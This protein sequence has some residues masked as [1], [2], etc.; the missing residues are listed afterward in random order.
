MDQTPV[1]QSVNQS[2]NQSFGVPPRHSTPIR[3]QTQNQSQMRNLQTPPQQSNIRVPLVTLTPASANA[4]NSQ[5]ER[6]QANP[7]YEMSADPNLNSMNELQNTGTTSNRTP[8]VMQSHLDQALNVPVY[9]NQ[10]MAAHRRQ[11]TFNTNLPGQVIINR[12]L[13]TQ[14]THPD[15]TMPVYSNNPNLT[16]PVDV[17]LGVTLPG[18]QAT[19]NRTRTTQGVLNRTLPGPNPSNIGVTQPVTSQPSYTLLRPG[20]VKP[21]WKRNSRQ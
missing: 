4:Y 7:S 20:A 13:P 10:T 6:L 8:F 2:V 5:Q 16:M 15:R 21:R 14:P 17:D 12:T 18:L 1:A 19:F 9:P 3:N 11:L